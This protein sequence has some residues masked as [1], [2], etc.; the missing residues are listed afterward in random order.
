M[1]VSRNAHN[2][3]SIEKTILNVVEETIAAHRMLRQNDRVLVAVSGGPD[4]VALLHILPE[5][6]A[7]FARIQLHPQFPANCMICILVVLL[8]FKNLF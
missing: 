5:G 7:I 3:S 6:P 1:P 4:S 8:S 2:I